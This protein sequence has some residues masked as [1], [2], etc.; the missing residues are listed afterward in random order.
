MS[1]RRPLRS[2]RSCRA[3]CEIV[4]CAVPKT[5]DA[6]ALAEDRGFS[7]DSGDRGH[8]LQ[9]QP[10]AEG[11]RGRRR[12]RPHQPGKHRRPR[13]GARSSMPRRQRASRCGSAPTP[14][15]CPS[16][17]RTSPSPTR[18]RRSST[19]RSRRCELLERLDFCDF[20]ISVKSTH[21]PTMIRAY[22]MLAAKVPYPLHLGVTEA[23]TPFHRLDQE[24]GRD[25]RAARR[26]DRRHDPRLA[27]GRPGRG[28]EGGVR[29]PEGARP[30][31][32]RAGDDLVPVLRSRQRRRR[33]AR[34]RGRGT[35]EGVPAGSSRSR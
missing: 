35:A 12:R 6:E 13:Q 15:R 11:D 17:C 20:K 4:R 34:K 21:V 23:G 22:R 10:R 19:Q 3:G 30:A 33:D 1:R 32:A 25:G 28:V 24:R 2:P 5:E 26:R 18:P 14:A 16:I 31:R 29:D 27:D 7:P 9:R 8:P